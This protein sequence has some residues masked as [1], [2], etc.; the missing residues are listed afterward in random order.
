R[1]SVDSP[2][3]TAECWTTGC[4]PFETKGKRPAAATTVPKR[5]K[6]RWAFF[7]Q[8]WKANEGPCRWLAARIRWPREGRMANREWPH[9]EGWAGL[10]QDKGPRRVVAKGVAG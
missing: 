10:G 6:W 2:R 9:G 4:G 3:P 1:S 8:D 7:R 5:W